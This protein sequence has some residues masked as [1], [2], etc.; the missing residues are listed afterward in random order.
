MI[1][2]D[3]TRKERYQKWLSNPYH[4]C[5]TC[6]CKFKVLYESYEYLNW[7]KSCNHKRLEKVF[8][9]KPIC[10]IT[11]SDINKYMKKTENVIIN[12]D[13]DNFIILPSIIDFKGVNL[14]LND[15]RLLIDIYKTKCKNTGLKSIKINDIN[16][17]IT[18]APELSSLL[19]YQIDI[20]DFESILWISKNRKHNRR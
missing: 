7:C 19:N 17:A 13:I 10:T 4:T 14:T 3:F 20:T 16:D 2:H 6:G 8:N 15:I 18:I 1:I 12:N 9:S 11:L 5:I